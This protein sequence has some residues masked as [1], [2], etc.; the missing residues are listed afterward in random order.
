MTGTPTTPNPGYRRRWIG[1]A[2]LAL[3][4][5]LLSLDVSV[6]YLALPHMA[7][8]LGADAVA[9]LWILDIYSFVLA[10][11]LVTMGTLGDARCSLP[12][13]FGSSIA[14]E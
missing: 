12:S 3:P 10:G 9:Q 7:A 1:L 13:E 8:D 6:L 14:A 5:L 4:T 2:V 11:F